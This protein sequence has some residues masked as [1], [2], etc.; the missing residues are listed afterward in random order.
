[1][2]AQVRLDGLIEHARSLS[3]QP[4][5]DGYEVNPDGSYLLWFSYFSRNA[6]DAVD[7]PVGPNNR[8]TPGPED[9][10]QPEHFRPNRNRGVFWCECR[11]TSRVRSLGN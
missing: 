5:F 7:V 11:K 8:F 9:R 6:E 4:V 2:A 3:V 10:G 1:M